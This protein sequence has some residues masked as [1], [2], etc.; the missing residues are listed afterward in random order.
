V[1][2]IKWVELKEGGAGVLWTSKMMGNKEHI[3]AKLAHGRK[4]GQSVL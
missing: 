2:A 4:M 1:C 3:T